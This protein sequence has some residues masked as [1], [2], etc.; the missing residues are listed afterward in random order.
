[1]INLLPP[2]VK[3]GYHYARRNV[4]L[5]RWVAACLVALVGLSA[6][7]TYGLLALHESTVRYDQQVVATGAQLQKDKLSQ[8]KRQ[9]EDMSNSLKLAV[10]VLSNEVLFSKLIQQ[11]GSVMPS[12]TVLTGLTIDQVKGGLELTADSTN[13]TAATQ[14]QINLADPNNKIFSEVD[15]ESIKQS[16]SAGLAQS[17]Y[18]YKVQLRALFSANNSFLFI[19]QGKKS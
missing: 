9:V 11:I 13:Y 5:R 16:S 2:D 3:S 4:V 10:Q 15:I 7:G 14:I 17:A 8:T 6:L 18:Q 12:G 19:N 1:M